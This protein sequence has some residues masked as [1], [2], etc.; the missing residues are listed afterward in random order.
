[1][2]HFL[3][4]MPD[5]HRKTR[6]ALAAICPDFDL[7]G[8]ITNVSK[9]AEIDRNNP[10]ITKAEHIYEQVIITEYQDD[11]GSYRISEKT[12]IAKLDDGTERHVEDILTNVINMWIDEL[13]TANLISGIEHF[14]LR[15][16][17]GIPLRI[18][19][20]EA[21]PLDLVMTQGLGTSIRVQLKKYNYDTGTSEPVDLSGSS[22]SSNLYKQGKPSTTIDI[23]FTNPDNGDEHKLSIDLT[24]DEVVGLQELKSDKDRSEFVF[25]LAEQRGLIHREERHPLYAFY[26][27]SV[28]NFKRKFRFLF[29]NTGNDA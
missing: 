27:R 12:V 19:S 26:L 16:T 24:P 13:S 11:E 10:Q 8:D 1:M 21:A 2:F 6:T 14:P 18:A 20:D 17:S 9:H 22:L 29:S 25:G 7:I 4:H 5:P 15:D 28:R 3:E 23:T